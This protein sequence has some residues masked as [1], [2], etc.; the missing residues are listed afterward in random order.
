[1]AE[2][3]SQIEVLQ[4]P[5]ARL[6]WPWGVAAASLAFAL[7]QATKRW[8]LAELMDPPRVVPVTSFFDLVLGRNR[9]VSFGLLSAEHP[10]TPWPLSAL[11]VAVVV[12]LVVWTMRDRRPRGGWAARVDARH[13]R[14]NLHTLVIAAEAVGKNGSSVVGLAPPRDLRLVEEEQT[15]VSALTLMGTI[16]PPGGSTGPEQFTPGCWRRCMRCRGSASWC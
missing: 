1:M 16:R 6:V 15:G 8:A 14:I 3:V 12:G 9:G 7:D 5:A 10:A 4:P 13:Q 2:G 11:A